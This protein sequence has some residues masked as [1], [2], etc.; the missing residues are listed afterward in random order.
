MS[1]AQSSFV[2]YELMTTDVASAKA[3]YSTVVGWMTQDMPMPGMTYTLLQAGSESVGGIMPVPGDALAGGLKP[4]WIG[5]LYADNVDSATAKVTALGGAVHHAPTDIPSVGRFSVVSDPQ[6]AMFH[7]FKPT[8]P[9]GE[10]TRSDVPGHVGWHELHTTDRPAAFEFYN[11]LFG[12]LKAEP[13][14]MGPMGI[15][16]LFT[17]NGAAIGGLFNSPDAEHRPFWLYYFTVEDIDA[18]S[19]R[20]IQAGGRVTQEVHQVPGG[21]WILR[22]TDRQG[23]GFALLGPRK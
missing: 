10:R 1:A 15:Y 18:A 5:Y 13:V 21:L 12:W 16:Q 11:A 4:T 22:A 3:F 6:G 9:S 20:V 7:L 23:A 14:D 2:W 8:T 19:L 17:V